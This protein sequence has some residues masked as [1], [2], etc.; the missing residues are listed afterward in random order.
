M[1]KKLLAAAIILFT[2]AT[3]KAQVGIGTSNPTN[4]FHVV[5]TG[6]PV[7]FEGLQ[8]GAS[9]DRVVVSDTSGVL[10]LA[11]TATS[12]YFYAPSAVLP[13]VNAN[14]PSYTTY[15]SSAG[16]FTVDLYAIYSNQYGLTGNVSGS[17]RTS[18]KN[19][20]ATTLPVLGASMLEYFIIYFDNTVFDPNSIT[21]SD[22]GVMTYKILP[23]AVVTEKTFMNIVFK[24]K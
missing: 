9:G 16:I 8:T 24:I 21:I 15:N 1:M 6:N 5:S 12:Q 20:T 10:R 2:M 22:T 11:P 18:L 4:T 23:S 7:R 17:T 3:S 19:A 13:T 14:L